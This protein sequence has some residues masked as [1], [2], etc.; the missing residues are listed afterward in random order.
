MLKRQQPKPRKIPRASN[1]TKKESQ[2][3]LRHFMP[4]RDDS[5]LQV[6]K[7]NREWLSYIRTRDYMDLE[8]PIIAQIISVVIGALC[9]FNG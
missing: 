9:Q 5:R 1:K 2:S 6:G 3:Y 8:L 4:V 7:E